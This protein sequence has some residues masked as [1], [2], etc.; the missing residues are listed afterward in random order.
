MTLN[1]LPEDLVSADLD[2]LGADMSP[3]RAVAIAKGIIDP[4]SGARFADAFPA[5]VRAPSDAGVPTTA[6][7][8]A[9]RGAPPASSQHS[10]EK[11][12]VVFR[13]A[14]PPEKRADIARATAVELDRVACTPL[15]AAGTKRAAHHSL[16]A[17]VPAVASRYFVN[18]SAESERAF[19]APR[20]SPG[21][22][23]PGP[24]LDLGS[25]ACQAPTPLVV[26]AAAPPSDVE[27]AGLEAAAAIPVPAAR[28]GAR[29]MDTGVAVDRGLTMDVRRAV[30]ASRAIDTGRTV[31]T[32][33]AVDTSVPAA[34]PH[35]SA[36]KY[37][38]RFGDLERMRW[39]TPQTFSVASLSAARSDSLSPLELASRDAPGVVTAT[40]ALRQL[41]PV[42]NVKRTFHSEL[43]AAHII[44]APRTVQAAGRARLGEVKFRPGSSGVAVSSVPLR[45]S[46]LVRGSSTVEPGLVFSYERHVSGDAAGT[47]ALAGLN[48]AAVAHDRSGGARGGRGDR[49]IVSPIAFSGVEAAADVPSD[50][51]DGA[52]TAGAAG[53]GG[54][55]GRGSSDELARG[56]IATALVAK[57]TLK[58]NGGVAASSARCVSATSARDKFARAAAPSGVMGG[59]SPMEGAGVTCLDMEVD[60]IAMIGVM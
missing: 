58:W 44:T 8:H 13:R 46:S 6:D 10:L 51:G 2:F 35:V 54:G 7:G 43:T 39:A 31:D 26:D 57:F 60:S 47:P 21:E 52:L 22:S 18:T 34:A 29:V 28:P 38:E 15:L 23:E 11:Y 49:P 32:G 59:V 17:Y 30:D 56:D 48:G 12:G 16:A 33:S 25:V 45:A 27:M 41:T 53:S 1:P 42:G 3:E 19:K 20:I 14:G 40:P 4:I 5:P 36:N 24:Q 50:V 55:G 37:G 9:A